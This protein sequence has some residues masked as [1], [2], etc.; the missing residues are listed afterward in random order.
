LNREEYIT[1]SCSIS[2]HI[3]YKNENPVFD[4]KLT[5]LSDFLDSAYLH[6]NIQ[7]PRFYKMDNLSKLGFLGV[8]VLL[9]D[10]FKAA[11]YEAEETG[12]VLANASASLD[13]DLKYYGTV[14]GIPSPALFVYTLPNIMIGEICIKHD[15]KGENA[16][17]VFKQFDAT[18]M[19]QYVSN[20]FSNRLLR[21]CICG[22]VELLEEKHKLVLFLIEKEKTGQSVLFTV[23]NIRTIFLNC[24]A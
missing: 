22:W 24:G 17:F 19:E 14:N 2:K 6:F 18:F 1:A 4:G 16:F 13:T 5:L 12:I 3:V 7:Y 20:L 9:K 8:E 10:D 15:F 23:E 11:R 21:A